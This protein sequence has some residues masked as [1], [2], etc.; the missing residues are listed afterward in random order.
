MDFVH[1]LC[2]TIFV[3]SLGFE[4]GFATETSARDTNHGH[5]RAL[6]KRSLSGPVTVPIFHI[7][8]WIMGGTNCV[9]CES[10]Y[11]NTTFD[12]RETADY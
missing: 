11:S 8:P 4:L 12:H 2:R 6:S 7:E 3:L 9:N 10:L 5:L 1:F